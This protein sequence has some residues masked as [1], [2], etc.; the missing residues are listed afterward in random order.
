MK[1]IIVQ[2][3]SAAC[4]MF[5]IVMLWF[6]GMGYLFAGPSYGLNL[7]MSVFGAALGMADGAQALCLL[8]P[9]R[10]LAYPRAGAGFGACGLPAKVI[11]ARGRACG[12]RASTI[13]ASGRPSP[14]WG[15]LL[16]PRG[17]RAAGFQHHPSARPLAATTRNLARY[18]EKNW[19]LSG[20]LPPSVSHPTERHTHEREVGSSARRSRSR[21]SSP[22]SCAALRPC[23]CST[24][25]SRWR[26]SACAP[27]TTPSSGWPPCSRSCAVR[28]SPSCS[29][30]I[31]P[32]FMQGRRQPWCERS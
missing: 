18:R 32:A 26:P 12:S 7:T 16:R 1:K 9:P 15:Y 28:C 25:N 19:P 2:A 8:A 5:T 22:T 21:T 27:W 30:T 24:T 20:R 6:T 17:L 29:N 23:S 14:S 31:R 10:K 3:A 11:S 4:I 13:P